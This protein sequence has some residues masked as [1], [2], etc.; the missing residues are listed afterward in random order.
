MIN[1]RK[2]IKCIRDQLIQR[3][4]K[5][6]K[7]RLIIIEIFCEN[8]CFMYANEVYMKVKNKT[9]GHSIST[10]YRNIELL[11]QV[12][13]LEMI[14]ISNTCYYKLDEKEKQKFNIHAKCVKC[15][16]IIEINEE[17]ISEDLKS[18]MDELNRKQMI[19]IKSTSVVLS[20][21]CKECELKLQININ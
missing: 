14:Y 1:K 19:D 12:G 7:A 18:Y 5:L 16:K 20:G 2:S 9:I 3:G 17:K 13:A 11:E 4:Y 10:I 6:T 8:D 21:I 15:N